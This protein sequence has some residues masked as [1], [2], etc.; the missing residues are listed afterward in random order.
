[1]EGKVGKLGLRRVMDEEVMEMESPEEG[2]WREIGNG[3][4]RRWRCMGTRNG[5][6]ILIVA[7]VA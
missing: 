6:A 7:A 4:V 1:M 5:V 3:E 2:G